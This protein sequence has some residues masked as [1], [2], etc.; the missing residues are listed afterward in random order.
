MFQREHP[1]HDNK[2]NKDVRHNDMIIAGVA[3]W[4]NELE[5]A[6]CVFP[7]IVSSGLMQSTILS[8]CHPHL[9]A[10]SLLIVYNI[11]PLDCEGRSHL[12]DPTILSH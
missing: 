11:L 1:P 5:N 3:K 7:L 6:G 2:R 10:I 8:L 4:G 9:E 12:M